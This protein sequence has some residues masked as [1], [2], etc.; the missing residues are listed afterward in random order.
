VFCFFGSWQAFGISFRHDNISN[1][2]LDVAWSY[3][4]L[5]EVIEVRVVLYSGVSVSEK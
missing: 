2:L 3:W 4:R 5:V 1:F